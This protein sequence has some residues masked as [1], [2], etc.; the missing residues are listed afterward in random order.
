MIVTGISAE[1][2][3]DAIDKLSKS[4]YSGNLRAEVGRV[5][6]GNRFAA[7]IVPKDS[8]ARMF[9]Q[10]IKTSAP[11]A[12][13][14]WSGRRINAACW[15]AYRDAIIA[16]FDINPDARVY[17]AMAK[18]VGRDGF[19]AEYPRTADKNIGSMVQPAYMPELCDCDHFSIDTRESD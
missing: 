3:S 8:G 9:G 16:V 5:Y 14:S 12:R 1:Q 10:K 2:F 18:Y 4:T 7:R 6:S 13:R 15:H 19:M 11:G 17:T